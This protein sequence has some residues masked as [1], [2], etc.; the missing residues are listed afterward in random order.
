LDQERDA[1]KKRLARY[2]QLKKLIEPFEE[3]QKNVQPNLVTRDGELSQEL[4]RMRVLLA[5]V[6][7]RVNDVRA[8]PRRHL[9]TDTTEEI[10]QQTDQ[11]RLARV[12]DLG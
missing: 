3:P 4:D 9:N 5:R 6:T 10:V 1:L 8:S 2:E 7:G 11:Q 12:M